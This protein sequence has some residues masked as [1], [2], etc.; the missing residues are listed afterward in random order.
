MK[1]SPKVT[2][3][4]ESLET[5]TVFQRQSFYQFVLSQV[6]N[7]HSPEDTLIFYRQHLEQLVQNDLRQIRETGLF[8]D[9][10]HP[11]S[12]LRSL[13]LKV[14]SAHQNAHAFIQDMKN[15]RYAGLCLSVSASQC[16]GSRCGAICPASGHLQ[17]PHYTFDPDVGSLIVTGLSSN[18]QA[19]EIYDVLQ[20]CPGFCTAA[21]TNPNKGNL[22]RE[23]RARFVTSAE[24]RAAISALMKSKPELFAKTGSSSARLALV[25]PLSELSALVIPPE[26]SSTE[27]VQQ[28]HDLCKTVVKR[29]NALVGISFEVT[30]ALLAC[31]GTIE[32]QLDLL[33]VY[34]R[35]VHHF[36]FYAAEWCSDEWDLR[37]KCGM[38]VVRD[39]NASSKKVQKS[40]DWIEGH[41]KRIEDFLRTASLT[42]PV[43][44]CGD[45]AA[46]VSTSDK[47]STDNTVYISDAKYQCRLC[48][49]C[50]RGTDYIAKHLKKVHTGLF[51]SV[52]ADDQIAAACAAYLDDEERPTQVIAS[53]ETAKLA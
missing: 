7:A 6:T 39:S 46:Q 38:V 32:F 26:M 28:D 14:S 11:S 12:A 37:R 24:A 35:R 48:G 8:F 30:E 42:R 10:Y 13:D 23:L 22:M 1:L 5:C 16:S 34:L 51:A 19:W 40:G 36:C 17:A 29:L 41:N 18:V 9:M 27:R 15:G 47:L 43:M 45:D 50:F 52:W 31:D 3:E 44:L 20:D 2:G 21:W 25:N 49:K 33:V 4:S 53:Q